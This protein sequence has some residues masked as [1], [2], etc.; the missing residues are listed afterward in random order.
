MDHETMRLEC[1]KLA[2][3]EGLT[4]DAMSAR[5]DYLFQ[6]TR[7]G[8]A[9]AD[10]LR[11]EAAA[12]ARWRERQPPGDPDRIETD[13]ATIHRHPPFKDYTPEQ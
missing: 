1:L 6:C 9:E 8:K 4:G 10:R 12:D 11:T 3:A 5:A 7:Y 2:Q 13:L